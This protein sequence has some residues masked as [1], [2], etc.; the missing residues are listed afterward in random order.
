MTENKVNLMDLSPKEMTEFFVSL[1]EKPFRSQQL[2]RWIYQFGVTDFAEMTNLRKDLRVKLQEKARIAAPEIVSEQR[3]AD[4][5]IKWALD[6]GDGQLVESVFI[7]EE[8]RNTLCISTQVGCPVKCAFC[9]T[10][11]GGFNR[12]LTLSEIIGQVFRAETIVGFSNNEEYKPISNVVMMGMGEP[13][14]NLKNVVAATEILLS[15]YAFALSKRR[16]TISTSGVAPI[17]EKIA[18]KVDVALALSLHAPNDELRNKLVPINQKYPIDE[19]LTAVRHYI[20]ASN[21][22]CGRVTIEYVLLDGINDGLEQAA[23]L[24]SLLRELPC[25]INLIPFNPH[26]D[27]PY[28]RPSGNRVEKF[29]RTLLDQ[30]FTVMKRSTRGDDISAACGQLAGQVKNRMHEQ[31]IASTRR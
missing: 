30:G 3:S 31:E 1:G 11:Q 27:S 5:T 26:E 20:D 7:P 2:L 28:R 4:G 21:A 16:V 29:Y 12:N 18:G 24:A 9:R 10:G 15:D 22:N 19:V 23:E 14:L 17:I 13:L 8:S 25:K 6:I